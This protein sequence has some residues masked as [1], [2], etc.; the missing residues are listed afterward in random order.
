[1]SMS[2]NLSLSQSAMPNTN[3]YMIFS[4]VCT[5]AL[6]VVC[7]TDAVC[8][9]SPL[10]ESTREW[11]VRAAN[12]PRLTHISLRALQRYSPLGMSYVSAPCVFS[13]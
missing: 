8:P 12:C 5:R 7:T 9:C 1:M 6:T 13:S 2:S 11:T 4:M 3:F 10:D